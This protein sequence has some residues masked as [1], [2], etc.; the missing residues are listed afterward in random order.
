[1]FQRRIPVDHPLKRAGEG[2]E[3]TGVDW[4]FKS[5]VRRRKGMGEPPVS[6]LPAQTRRFMWEKL[7]ESGLGATGKCAERNLLKTVE[8]LRLSTTR[9]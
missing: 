4:A 8:N 9:G 5:W 6:A 1:M 7:C 3:G 2:F